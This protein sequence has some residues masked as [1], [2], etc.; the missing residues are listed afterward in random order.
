M[1]IFKVS[2]ISIE[3]SNVKMSSSLFSRFCMIVF[4]KISLEPFLKSSLEI[5]GHKDVQNNV[6][7]SLVGEYA[8]V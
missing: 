8:V 7:M 4:P 5:R 6:K 2:C 1:I 3:L